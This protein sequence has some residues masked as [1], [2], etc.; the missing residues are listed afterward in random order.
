MGALIRVP[1]VPDGHC[2][3]MGVERRKGTFGSLEKV[4]LV[5]TFLESGWKTL[6]LG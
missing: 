5:I 1:R 2:Q 3:Y 4:T 6:I